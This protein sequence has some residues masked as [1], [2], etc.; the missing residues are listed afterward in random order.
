[1][2]GVYSGATQLALNDD[3]NPGV[4]TDSR[5]TVTLSGAGPFYLAVTSWDDPDFNGSGAV[6]NGFYFA[7]VSINGV[8][9]TRSPRGCPGTDDGNTSA[10]ASVLAISA[11]PPPNGVAQCLAECQ[12]QIADDP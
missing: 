8:A 3:I 4:V 9:M 11:L 10:A 1:M 7:D 5:L 12:A 6:T 2:I